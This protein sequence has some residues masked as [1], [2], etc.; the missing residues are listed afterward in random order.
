PSGGV[1]DPLSME[2][3]DV[4]PFIYSINNPIRFIDP[5]GNQVWDMTTDKAHKSALAKFANTEQGKAFL[6]QYAKA[7][8]V[9]GGVRFDA[10]GKYSHQNV[11]FYSHSMRNKGETWHYLR[12][13]QTRKGLP[14]T[15]VT[16][17]TVRENQGELENLS[18]SVYLKTGMDVNNSLETIGHESFI[19]VEKT[20]KDVESGVKD[21]KNGKFGSGDEKFANFGRF[22]QGLQGDESDHKLAVNGKVTNMEEF[23]DALDQVF[24]GTMFRNM[25]EDWKKNPNK[26]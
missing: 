8:D 11:A 12:T 4:S 5:D 17:S 23:V 10:D 22:M 25:F 1:V 26:H 3:H 15:Q 14:L 19:H 7:G 9:I 21:L 16:G 20:T 13:K 2:Y 6:A 18:F 24:G